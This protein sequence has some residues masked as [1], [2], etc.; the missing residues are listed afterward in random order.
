MAMNSAPAEVPCTQNS[1]ASIPEKIAI[2]PTA[3]LE[4][5]VLA[6]QGGGSTITVAVF[7][8]APA[9]ARTVV[10]RSE[11]WAV[12]IAPLPKLSAVTIEVSPD[13]TVVPIGTGFPN[14]SAARA[15]SLNTS[16]MPSSRTVSR[17]R[18]IWVSGPATA[19]WV[20]V[21][22]VSPVTIAVACWLPMTGPRVH[23]IVATPL[24]SVSEDDAPRVPDAALHATVTPATFWPWASATL[25]TSGFASLVA[26]SA[27][28]PS[29]DTVRTV[30][31]G[32]ILGPDASPHAVIWVTTAVVRSAINPEANRMSALRNSTPNV[33]PTHCN[34]PQ[35]GPISYG[36]VRG[37]AWSPVRPKP[38]RTGDSLTSASSATFS[39]KICV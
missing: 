20:N 39:T 35:P 32:P 19:V 25:I 36:R 11:A 1:E 6:W 30:A 4:A 3:R 28:C 38:G 12:R 9:I 24:A 5:F 23:S 8:R 18:I 14:L 2:W 27:V 13:S 26:T 29:P 34:E 22:G 21:T 37:S 31:G 7:V 10:V 17:V 33:R 16:P 15:L